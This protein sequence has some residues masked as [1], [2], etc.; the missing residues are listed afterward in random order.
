MRDMPVK[1]SKLSANR[2]LRESGFSLLEVLVT[3]SI[4][5]TTCAIAIPQLASRS[6]RLSLINEAT[7][8]RLFLERCQ[9]LALSSR[10]AVEVIISQNKLLAIYQNPA[11]FSLN[12]LHTY[13]LK[14]GS[15]IENNKGPS[16][17]IVFYPSISASPDS[18]TIT[19]STHSC[20]III[21]LR[22]R[23][24]HVC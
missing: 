16:R 3:I 8:I 20:S 22:G 12:P 6:A 19:R 17:S 2:E 18:F 9:T 10:Q 21:S 11:A 1:Y 7:S 5:A 4:V 13:T 24:R 14:A 23:I 15:N